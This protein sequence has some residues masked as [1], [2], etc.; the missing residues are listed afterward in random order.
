[1]LILLKVG[2]LQIKTTAKIHFWPITL[3]KTRKLH[4]TLWVKI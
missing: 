1:M 2:E 3:A 4:D